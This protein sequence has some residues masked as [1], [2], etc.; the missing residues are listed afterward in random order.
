M[1]GMFGIYGDLLIGFY[2]WIYKMLKIKITKENFSDDK[3]RLNA[4]VVITFQ[5]AYILTWSV[6]VV[7]YYVIGSTLS[8]LFALCAGVLPSVIGIMIFRKTNKYIPAGILSNTA[9]LTALFLIT[10]TTGGGISAV[11]QWMIAVV[12]GS[13]LQM[14]KRYG[15]L[16]T[17]YAI[18]LF[19]VVGIYDYYDFPSNYQLPFAIDSK[20]FMI[21]TLFNYIFT[22]FIVAVLVSIFTIRFEK[23]FVEVQNAEK[24]AKAAGEAKSVFL[25]NMS[26]E[27]RTPIN[28]VIGITDLVLN[29]KLDKNQRAHVE[30]IKISGERLLTIVNDILD[31]SKIE[32]NLI[33]FNYEKISIRKIIEEIISI[34]NHSLDESRVSI[35]CQ[36]EDKVPEFVIGDYVRIS[37]II[38][39][40]TANAIKFT[41]SGKVEI[42]CKL[43]EEKE[44]LIKIKISVKDTGIG[45][46]KENQ[47]LLFKKF[48]QL[49]NYSTKKYVGT[50]L[51]LSISKELVNLMGGEIGVNSVV[52]EGSEFWFTIELKKYLVK[53]SEKND[54][55]I[56]EENESFKGLKVLV[57]EDNN[58]NKIVIKGILKKLEIYNKVAENGKEALE[59]LNEEKFDLILMDCQMPVLDG[60]EA[61][62]R[63][64]S[65][66]NE[67]IKDIPIIALTANAMSEEKDKCLC[68]GMNDL[69]TKPI[70]PKILKQV[71]KKW[72]S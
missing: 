30:L 28:G 64:R 53:S 9:S 27:I 14:G 55:E 68:C 22:T 40:L 25:A 12:V 65:S 36:I 52:N 50:G 13:F 29:T 47:K 48:S 58:I 15:N 1:G 41:T 44:D 46:S 71:I 19:I 18:L 3:D 23:G 42:N 16:L 63:I 51:G 66:D 11:L 57:V 38:T 21:Y 32:A 8:S 35:L 37:Q 31:F 17:I 62:R 43:F 34:Q 45:I 24:K 7:L 2:N 67:N 54:A 26:H 33:K 72:M 39:N 56:V 59:I 10:M 20:W 61:T 6:Y 4:N 5:I 49:E 60:Y 70:N 69:V